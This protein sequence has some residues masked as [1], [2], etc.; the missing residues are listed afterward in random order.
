MGTSES[1]EEYIAAFDTQEYL[2]DYAQPDQ[3]VLFT[4][5]FMIQVLREMP[6]DLLALEFGGGPVLYSAATMAPWVR[7]IHFCDYLPANLDAVQRWLDN[8][9]DAFDWRPHLKLILEEE[10]QAA[11]PMAIARRAAE[12]R[13][14]ITRLPV[15]DALASTPLGQ[16]SSQYDLLVAHHCTDVAAATVSEWLQIMRNI[17]SLIAP[18]GWLL[19]SV[20]TGASSDTFIN[21]V[22][23]KSFPCVDLSDEEICRGYIAAGCNLDTFRLDKLAVPEG[24]EYSGL[25]VAIARKLTDLKSE[26]ALPNLRD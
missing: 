20:T 2:E 15:C 14:K 16:S 6:S 11:T 8:Q 12:L 10:G 9:A 4:I 13:R 22:D 3:E 25:T 5:R 26:A 17:S 21:T 7:E 18:G 19:I 24:R 23:Q 1:K